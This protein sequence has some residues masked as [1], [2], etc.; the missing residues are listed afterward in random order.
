M[1]RPTLL[2]LLLLTA[3]S[4]ARAQVGSPRA[5]LAIGGSAGMVMN[6]VSF[7]PVI[8]QAWKNGPTLGMTARYT[9]EKYFNMLCAFQAELNYSQAGWREVIDTSADTYER[10]VHYLQLP[11]LAHL[12]FGR[13]RGGAK[14]YLVLGPQLGYSVGDTQKRGGEWSEQ[15]L[16]LRRNGVTQQYDLPV[17]QRFEYGITG[18]I[19][20]DLSTRSGHHFLVEGRYF[21]G[22]SDIFSNSKK[23]PFGRSANGTI[24]AKVSY[25]FDILRYTPH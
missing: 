17:Q 1:N 13:E 4:A 7:T 10:T 21:Y 20:L 24:I 22:L 25:L 11:L 9:C 16:A 6:R 8:K 14:G 23:D 5:D 18:G 15:T 19:G 12:G 3:C 2:L